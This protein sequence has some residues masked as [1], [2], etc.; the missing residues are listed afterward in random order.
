VTFD[1]NNPNVCKDCPH[2]GK[3][4][5]P[6]VLGRRF[7][8]SED[9][10]DSENA[11]EPLDELTESPEHALV[12]D[13]PEHI[14][15]TYPRPYFRGASGGVFVRSTNADGETDERVIYQND[16]YVTRRLHDVEDG[17]MVVVRL[18]LPK[19]GVREFTLQL[20]ALTS[21]EEFRKNMAAMGVAILKQDDLQQYM[22]TWVNELQAKS[23]ADTAHRQYGWTSDDCRSFVVG[24]KEIHPNKISY[25]PM[26][27]PTGQSYPSFKEK[28]TLEGWQEM[29]NFYTLKEGMEMHQYIVC[30]AFGS[31]LMQFLPQN[32]GTMHVHDK[33]GG[34]GKTA[35]MKVAASVWGHFKGTM[36][37]D[38]D[39]TSFKMNRGEV[40]HNLPFYTRK[41]DEWSCVSINQWATAR[42][43]E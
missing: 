33:E 3:I 37:D 42:A 1:E 23:V 26:T 21:R 8:A 24:D 12:D 28:G 43:Y 40:L 4:K 35:A 31:P 2:W 7:K 5:S 10:V 9:H 14:I 19:D 11:A 29:A 25:N 41:G 22:T 13:T 16:I 27:G 20:K 17:E 6:I 18:H 30:T 36:V 15:P 32:C 34:A 38:N 39:T